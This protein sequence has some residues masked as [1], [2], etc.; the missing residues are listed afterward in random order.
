MRSFSSIHLCAYDAC[1]L[2]EALVRKGALTALG[3]ESFQVQRSCLEKEVLLKPSLSDLV[4]PVNPVCLDCLVASVRRSI[5]QLF[6]FCA[7]RGCLNKTHWPGH[8]HPKVIEVI[9]PTSLKV[10]DVPR[11]R[12]K[13]TSSNIFRSA[14]GF[15]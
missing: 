5:R 15:K 8:H 2:N 10:I 3:T 13:K 1:V 12:F 7:S 4:K 6:S 9:A 11:A 14:S